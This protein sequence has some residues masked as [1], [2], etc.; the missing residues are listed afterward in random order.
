MDSIEERLTDH[1]D[2]TPFEVRMD[3]VNEIIQIFDGIFQ[4][5]QNDK[6][7]TVVGQM[8]FDWFP[9]PGVK[10]QGEVQPEIKNVITF[11]SVD[12]YD[13]LVN[14]LLVGECYLSQTSISDKIHLEGR[15]QSSV[16]FGD[17]A[18]NVTHVSFAVP[19]LRYFR[20]LPIK[21][22]DQG[23]GT[24]L[25]TGRM[26][27][28]NGE[29]LILLDKRFE[30]EALNRSLSARGGFLCLYSGMITSRNSVIQFSDLRKCLRSLHF[31]LTFL[32][33]RRCSPLFLKGSFEGEVKWSDYSAYSVD[34]YKSVV[35]WPCKHSIDGLDRL[36]V[37]WSQVY[38]NEASREV[39]TSAIHWYVEANSNS[40]YVEGSIIMTQAA[41]ELMYNWVI[42]E[43]LK[44]II[45][46]DAEK[47]SAANKI[48]LLLGQ[49]SL[50]TEVPTSLKNL[51]DF[52]KSSN[53]I[54][55]GPD[56]FVK[57]RNAIVHSH[58]EKRKR[59][60]TMS[61]MTRYEALQ[62]GLWYLELAILYSLGFDGRYVNRCFM[63]EWTGQGEEDVPWK[64]G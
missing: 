38:K 45:W 13:V 17:K 35:S 15:L 48:R 64:Q 58:E 6:S 62:L 42:V 33:G 53:D 14:G 31:F 18:I 50:R 41:L 23:K 9:S 7:I 11:D 8:F 5:K 55:D 12:K 34:Q 61:T 27:F 19:N 21:Q 3:D 4:L 1:P 57:I 54:I 32:N 26:L 22:S 10:F 46:D 44:L 52:F 28:E 24:K 60:S 59:L 63:P 16:V 49:M 47:I 36:W 51:F 30:F 20:G 40:G 25:S 37:N 39:L 2:S 43:K 56:C 29:F